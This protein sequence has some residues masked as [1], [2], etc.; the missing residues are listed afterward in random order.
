MAHGPGL[1][2]I[3]F[4]L[5]NEIDDMMW[6]NIS[7]TITGCTNS[8][9]H[10]LCQRGIHVPVYNVTFI[11]SLIG[12]PNEL[13]L[14]DVA[15]QAGL[16]TLDIL[17]QQCSQQVLVRLAKHCVRWKLT[18]FHLELTKTDIVAVDG[19]YRSVD[20]KRIG[21]LGRWKDKFADKAT[22]RVFIEALMSC[23]KAS[24]A[25]DACK[26]IAS[27]KLQANQELCF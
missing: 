16:K 18:G 20:E 17:D 11:F 19:D 23:G 7:Q 14:Q 15:A 8:N 24:D 22:Y 21:M 4:N 2:L 9:T 1:Y 12:V 3:C 26:T 13:S 5:Q 6:H 10:I 25:I 27:S